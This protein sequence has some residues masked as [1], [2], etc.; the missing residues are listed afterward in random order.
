M[1]P[2]CF[3][4]TDFR[5]PARMYEPL[6]TRLAEAFHLVAPDYPGFGHSESPDPK[7]FDYTFDNIARIIERFTEILRLDR[8]LTDSGIVDRVDVFE[9]ERSDGRYLGD[10][11]S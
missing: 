11:G 1:H 8:L 4:F 6:F 5:R 10:V 3:S 9:A 7:G 2:F